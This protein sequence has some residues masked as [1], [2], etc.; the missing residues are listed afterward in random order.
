L[1]ADEDSN[2]RR[3]AAFALGTMGA[4]ASLAIDHL[5]PMLADVE[6]QTRISAEK[7][8]AQIGAP[9]VRP[10]I[11]ILS[12]NSEDQRKHAIVALGDIGPAAAEAVPALCERLGDSSWVA[13]KVLVTLAKI[14]PS[15]ASAISAVA[16]LIERDDYDVAPKAVET[17]LAIGPA[18]QK[19]LSYIVKAFTAK[20]PEARYAAARALPSFGEPALAL[21]TL[22][23]DDPD[24]KVKIGCALAL[25]YFGEEAT[26]SVPKLT[27]LMDDPNLDVR[28]QACRTKQKIAPQ[29]MTAREEARLQ[30]D[31]LESSRQSAMFFARLGTPPTREV[32]N[33]LFPPG[34]AEERRYQDFVVGPPGSERR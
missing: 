30:E 4:K 12:S 22:S 23:L 10:L 14:G 20:R 13:A 5:I 24:P 31:E 29:L 26:V 18:D 8:L 34:S 2:I 16:P 25:S 6:E 33:K 32:Y 15:A 28:I 21:L 9:A 27:K 17:L 11:S 19:L 1:G 7:A 3:M